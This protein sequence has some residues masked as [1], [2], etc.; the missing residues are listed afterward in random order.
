ME[1]FDHNNFYILFQ[2]EI[3]KRQIVTA[4]M[5]LIIEI[6]FSPL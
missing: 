3:R 4:L 2:I 5:I 6:W 1:E